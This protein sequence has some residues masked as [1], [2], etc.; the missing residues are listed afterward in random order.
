MRIAGRT[1][2]ITSVNTVVSMTSTNS[3]SKYA[4]FTTI[5]KIAIR[6]DD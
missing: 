4:K 1:N 2:D 5:M 6:V 3:K